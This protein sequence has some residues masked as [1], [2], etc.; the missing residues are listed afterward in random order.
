MKTFTR[1][2]PA[3]TANIDFGAASEH[4]ARVL[5][6]EVYALRIESA[7]VVPSN[8][9]NT[10][11][12][13]DLVE[14]ES[15]ARVALQPLWVDGPNADAG[16]LAG[17]NRYLIA[18]LLELAGQPTA[19]DPRQLIPTLVG[20]TFEAQLIICP[21]NRTGRTFNAIGSILVNGGL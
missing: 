8:N 11:V 10:L 6:P 1:Q 2:K 15:G 20:L 5:D 3:A 13:F 4:V 9:S 14:V 7:R 17:E 16:L 18:Q 19:G 21:D 12:V